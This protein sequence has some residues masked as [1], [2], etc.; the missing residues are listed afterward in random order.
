MNPGQNPPS[1]RITSA[2]GTAST[3]AHSSTRL[4]RFGGAIIALLAAFN[5]SSALANSDPFLEAQDAFRRGNA[6]KLHAAAGKLKNHPLAPYVEYYQWRMNIEQSD[7]AEVE[8]L[9]AK[10]SGDYLAEVIRTDWLKHLGHKARW[11]RFAKGWTAISVPDTELRC[12]ALES[13]RQGP[14]PLLADDARQLWRSLT[15]LPEACE[16]FFRTAIQLS[17]LGGDDVWDRA[18]RQFEAGRYAHA[19]RALSHLPKGQQVDD[20]VWAALN[21]KTKMFLDG[22]LA[23]AALG[24]RNRALASLAILRLARQSPADA[25]DYLNRLGQRIPAA[26]RGALWGA[27]ATQAAM[28]HQ[29]E[30]LEWFARAKGAALYEEQQRWAVR[31][32]LRAG[33]WSRVRQVIEAMPAPLAE[34]PAW[35]YW[36]GRALKAEGKPEAAAM[37]WGRI[38]EQSN[39]YGLLAA[40]ELDRRFS[41]PPKAV[42]PSGEEMTQVAALGSV[43]RALALFKLELRTEGIREWGWG[44]RGMSDR[45]LLAAAEYAKRQHI[46]DR[47]INAAEK[48]QTEHDYS[49]RY[50]TPYDDKV[51][52]AAKAAALDDAWVYGLMRQ[53]SRFITVAKSSVGA[54]GLMQLMPATARWVAKK[55]KLTDYQPSRVSEIDINVMLGTTYLRMV[56]ES[57]DKHPVLASAAYNAGPGRARRWRDPVRTLEG[58]IYTES[59]PFSETRDYVKKVLANA[60]IYTSLLSGKPDSLKAR[61]GV[62]KSA[63]KSAPPDEDLP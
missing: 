31:A 53:E 12:L 13:R 40:E 32:A 29:P 44:L 2:G 4:R 7:D 61:L 21:N 33:D 20:R 8:A 56:Y 52:P 30:A 9:T 19:R 62:V 6:A 45:Q 25:A 55:L 58:A 36:L 28:T 5:I 57:L 10:Y 41:L 14:D 51:R 48:T 3:S 1:R 15:D 54:Q 22:L 43:K 35:I 26:E 63:A 11:E 37:L 18:R 38:A 17:L 16:N 49:L 50:L 47:A 59:I 27:I 42:A 60:V 34:E 24:E 39:F 46:Y 23:N